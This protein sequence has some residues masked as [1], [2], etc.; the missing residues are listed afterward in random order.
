MFRC[1]LVLSLLLQNCSSFTPLSTGT[2]TSTRVNRQDFL[3]TIVA[4]STAIVTSSVLLPTEPAHARGRATLEYAIDRYYP[5]I[6]A[7]GVFY[8]NDLKK[9]IERND[10]TAIKAAT[11]EPPKRTK[12]DKSKVDGGIAERAAQAGGFSNARVIAATEL[13]SA[14]FSDNSIAP[15]TKAMK[16]QVAILRE[17]VD[18]MNTAAKIALGEEKVGGGFFGIGAKG[19]SQNELAQQVRDLYIKGGNAYNQY[20]FLANDDLPVTFKRLPYL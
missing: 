5:R 16:E 3:T 7:G 15:K 19:P 17:V 20:V 18:G 9:A 2:G 11:A 10:W 8:A 1:L 13:Y 4:S 14:S 6:E 12:E